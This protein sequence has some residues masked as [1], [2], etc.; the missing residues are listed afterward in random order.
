MGYWYDDYE[1]AEPSEI[2]EIVSDAIK[3]VTDYIINNS[4]F[5]I[6]LITGQAAE[7][8]K[9]YNECKTE[10]RK[11][12][13]EIMEKSNQIRDLQ[14]ELERKRT[15]L[16]ILPFEP[17]EQVYFIYQDRSST[18]KFTCP[19]CNGKGKISIKQDG[20]TYECTCPI[21]KD[22]IYGT[23]HPHREATFNPYRVACRDIVRID[24]AVTFDNKTRQV[25]TETR[26][27][28]DGYIIPIEHIRKKLD[29]GI[30]ANQA[31]I[32]ELETIASELNT[33]LRDGCLIKVGREIPID[34]S[35]N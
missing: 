6:E 26:Y 20:M 18:E 31:N 32:K 8:E 33:C 5:D 25:N 19:K 30:G 16:G 14:T 17:G 12:F 27:N 21:C 2:D 15:Q 23:D 1:P 11:F 24:Q 10:N 34:E 29:G 35:I 13:S 3:K 4:K 28:V 9:K 7:W 22:S